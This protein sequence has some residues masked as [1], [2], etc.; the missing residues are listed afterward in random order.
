MGLLGM[1][2][3]VGSRPIFYLWSFSPLWFK[4]KFNKKKLI[5]WNNTLMKYLLNSNQVLK[6]FN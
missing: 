5:T 6:I 4:F 3:A 2:L 1:G